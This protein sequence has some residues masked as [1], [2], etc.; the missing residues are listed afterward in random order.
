MSVTWFFFFF[1]KADVDKQLSGFQKASEEAEKRKEEVEAQLTE[2]V[3]DHDKVAVSLILYVI[4]F[5]Q[6]S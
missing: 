3:S 4:F 1:Q 5:L 2:M 6:T